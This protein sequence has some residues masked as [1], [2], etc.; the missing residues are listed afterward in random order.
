MTFSIILK[1][2]ILRKSKFII[3]LR[4]I[5]RPIEFFRKC[6]EENGEAALNMLCKVIQYQKFPSN[7][8]IVNFG[9]LG[10]TF[11]IILKGEVSNHFSNF[12]IYRWL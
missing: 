2:T 11:Y 7:T 6:K 12:L 9:E 1:L 3:V 8:N 5:S 10:S 4:F